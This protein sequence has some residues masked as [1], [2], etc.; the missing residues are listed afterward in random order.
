MSSLLKEKVKL[1]LSFISEIDEPQ[2]EIEDKLCSSYPDL[3][4]E[5]RRDDN[6][7]MDSIYKKNEEYHDMIQQKYIGDEF[8]NNCS[9]YTSKISIS[10]RQNKNLFE[11]LKDLNVPDDV[12]EEA[13]AMFNNYLANSLI[14][15]KKRICLKFF[16]IYSAYRKLKYPIVQYKLAKDMGYDKS[17]VT[18]SNSLFNEFETG[19]GNTFCDMTVIEYMPIFCDGIIGEDRIISEVLPFT[20]YFMKMNP[21]FNQ[22]PTQIVAAGIF[23]CYCTVYGIVNINNKT[24]EEKAGRTNATIDVMYK[25]VMAAYNV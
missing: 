10:H 19:F 5:L 2:L 17:L 20:A 24:I 4:I 14:R 21:I 9:D 11:G 6:F 8:N 1:Y 22:D 13:N 23:K 12:R 15:K 3:V 25:R 18:K 7:H 16:C